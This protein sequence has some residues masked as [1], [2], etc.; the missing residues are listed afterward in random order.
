[1]VNT[2][3]KIKESI[4]RLS[5]LGV[6]PAD[7]LQLNLDVI[8][9]SILSEVC[10]VVPME[11]PRQ[12]ISCLKLIYDSE[13][14]C[15]LSSVITGDVEKDIYKVLAMNGVGAVPYND[16]G[17]ATNEVHCSISANKSG[18]YLASYQNILPSSINIQDEIFDDGVGNLVRNDVVVGSVDYSTGLFKFDNAPASA[19]LSYKF[20]IY[21]IM[22]DRNMIKFVK[23]FVEVFADL[24]Q[25]DL[26]SALVLNDFKTLDLKENIDKILPQVLA[27]QIDQYI[28]TKYFKQAKVNGGIDNKWSSVADWD[29]ATRVPVNLLYSDLGTYISKKIGEFALK[30]GVVPN[31][32]LVTPLSYGILSQSEKFI[33][34]NDVEDLNVGTPKVVG[35]YNNTKVVLTNVPA[36]LGEVSIVL[37][38]KGQSDAQAAGVYTPFIPVT[39]RT[40]Q[41][42]E[43]AGMIVTSNVYSSGG[44]VM[45][46]PDLV[47][48]ITII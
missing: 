23:T 29:T 45:I 21:N 14:K 47:E 12:I 24:Y 22:T 20:D 27:Q 10:S 19:T 11:S 6:I 35:Y 26:D 40:V 28:M 18:E 36:D 37:T 48:G 25:L 5:S 44:F 42:A 1:M 8:Y 2:K 9:N 34:V 3:Q 32:M 15:E 13:N 41:G 38:Y 33:P 7:E 30:H 46:N 16:Y 39:L 43:S 4:T 31:V 17:Y